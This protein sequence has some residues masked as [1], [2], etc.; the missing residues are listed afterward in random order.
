MHPPLTGTSSAHH[1]VLEKLTRLG[2]TDVEV[3]ITG[4][5]GVGKE[6]YSRFLHENSKRSV[7]P[8]VSVNCGAL[9]NDLI[10]N[11]LFGHV[12]G[13]FTGALP[14]TDGLVAEA[15]NGTLFLDEVDSLTLA[16]Q[17]KLLRFIQEKEYRKLGETRLRRA[18]V[19]IVAASNADLRQEVA[20]KRFRED[21]F[22]RLQVVHVS[23]PPL[24]ARIDDVPALLAEFV[25]YFA[26]LH[27]LPP[28]MFSEE[29]MEH[30]MAYDWPGNVR[31]LA[32]CVQ[33]LTC[34]RPDGEVLPEDLPWTGGQDL[35]D[36]AG[37]ASFQ[38]FREAKRLLVAE[39][40]RT[41]IQAALRATAGNIGRAARLSEKP[42]RVFYELM[43]KHNIRA[44][45]YTQPK[46]SR[47]AS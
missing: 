25:R 46:R 26:Q 28:V 20:G 23:I 11:E 24:C 18:D 2:A 47:A 37:E 17:V 1:A 29:A 12:G 13:A 31:E 19:R 15:E 10:E 43:R 14:R 22:F 42:R 3:L 16:A 33:G 8:F 40:E 45:G 21:L 34:L 44:A 35:D 32:N 36:A 38:S 41:Y 7:R 6:L 30:M 5:T 39:F 4:P 9:P 27:R